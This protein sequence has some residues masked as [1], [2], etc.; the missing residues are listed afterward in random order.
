M[1]SKV[2]SLSPADGDNKNNNNGADV[3]TDSTVSMR[4]K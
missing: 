3:S 4:N 2:V 1:S